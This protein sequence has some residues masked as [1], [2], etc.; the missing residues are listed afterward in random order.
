MLSRII[1]L[2]MTFISTLGAATIKKATVIN[3]FKLS[4]DLMGY[5]QNVKTI[6]L[7]CKLI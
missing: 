7:I 2:S 3:W 1:P 5:I 6:K 4:D